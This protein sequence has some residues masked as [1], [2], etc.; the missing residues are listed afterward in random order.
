MHWDD[1]RDDITYD[2]LYDANGSANDGQ[3]GSA[4]DI[5]RVWRAFCYSQPD[6]F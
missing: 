2:T 1:E 6:P 4:L 3:Y 5:F